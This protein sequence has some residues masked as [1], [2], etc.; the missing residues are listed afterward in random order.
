MEAKGILK[1]LLE[2]FKKVGKTYYGFTNDSDGKKYDCN[3][4]DDEWVITE[5][6]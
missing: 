3:L 6:K 5:A 1:V 2:K 4:V